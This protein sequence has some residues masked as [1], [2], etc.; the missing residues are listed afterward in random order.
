MVKKL[1][2]ILVLLLSLLAC[3]DLFRPGFFPMHDDLQIARIYQMDKCFKDGQFPCRWVPDMGYGYGYPLY[4]FYPPLPFYLGEMVHLLGASFIDSIKTIFILGMI[5]SGFFMYLLAKEFWGKLGGL[6]SA[7]FYIWAPYH[8][9]NLYVRG[10]MNEYWA[11]TFFPLIFWAIYKVIKT[12]KKYIPLLAISFGGLLLTHNIMSMLF[13]PLM[14]LWA[15]FLILWDKERIV[16]R[17]EK[18]DLKAI[19]NLFFGIFWGVGLGLFFILPALVEKKFVHVETMFMGYFNYLAHHVS[20]FQLFLS[21]FWGYGAS[22]WGP[23]DEMPFQIGFLH[24]GVGL[25]V[26]GLFLRLWIKKKDKR[27]FLISFFM[28]IFLVASFLAH[29]RSG[30]IWKKIPPLEYL[31]FPWRFLALVIFPLSFVSGGL[32]SFLRGA[33]RQVLAVL[34]IFGV[35]AISFNYFKPEKIININDQ[36]K[37]FSEKGMQRL[38]TDAIFDYLPKFA[39]M[40]P[41]SLAPNFAIDKNTLEEIEMVGLEKGTNWMRFYSDWE[42]DREVIIPQYYFPG[43]QGWIDEEKS[44][45]GYEN[46]LGRIVVNVPSG[47]HGIYLRLT[48]TPVRAWANFISLISWWGLLIVLAG[49]KLWRLIRDR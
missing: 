38:Y 3:R 32:L 9:V 11:I 44:I 27:I 15:I 30:L 40:P 42:K 23:E 21:R 17:I 26:L 47:A 43:W 49:P 48:N 8:A 7:A 25:L 13:I 36:E 29:P 39:P 19:K 28:S 16:F 5:L 34:L 2:L 24:W 22:V 33:K 12:G 4:N 41:T 37:L 20:L 35:V 1:A 6:V 31:Q 18:K 10:A 45:L 46:D 14:G